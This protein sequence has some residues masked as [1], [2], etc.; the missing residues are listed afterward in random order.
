[1]FK[2]ILC[3]ISVLFLFS[4]FAVNAFAEIQEEIEQ[5]GLYIDAGQY[6]KAETIYEGIQESVSDVNNLLY[7]LP[8]GRDVSGQ[9]LGIADFYRG[10]DEYASAK[11]IYEYVIETWPEF[12]VVVGVA[13]L[14][15][16]R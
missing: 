6:E 14:V 16:K 15:E 7:N 8:E 11:K 10:A 13:R 4:V 12:F 2:K 9:L 3:A 1:M 5:A